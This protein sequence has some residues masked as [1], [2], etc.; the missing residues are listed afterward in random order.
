M[1]DV[2]QLSDDLAHLKPTLMPCVP[3]LLNRMVKNKKNIYFLNCF[4]FI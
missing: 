1:G 2:R 4:D 3:R